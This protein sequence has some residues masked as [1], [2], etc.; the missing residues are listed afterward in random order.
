MNERKDEWMEYWNKRANESSGY[1][2]CDYKSI[3]GFKNRK[4]V[5]SQMVDGLSGQIIDVGCGSGI[6]SVHF[7]KKGFATYGVDFSR[8][9]IHDAIKRSNHERVNA[10]F[11]V[12]DVENL[13]F[14][15]EK[16]DVG[17]IIEVLQNIEHPEGIIREVHRVMK[18]NA[19]L[20]IV[21]L[22]KNSPLRLKGR[23]VDFLR[24]ITNSKK[25]PLKRYTIPHLT[26]ILTNEG[27]KEIR[28]VGI[29]ISPISKPR[30]IRCFF[31]KVFAN[32]SLAPSFAIE[33]MKKR[34]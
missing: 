21:I 20:V 4:D 6:Y 7:A 33:G 32:P 1:L 3:S 27:Y 11:F 24:M 22:N 17:L 29:P 13:P 26:K 14:K 5:V 9:M 12:A 19:K 8:Q 16:F 10:H 34:D 15:S 30:I 18:N 25:L 28:I 2:Q 31:E 23:C